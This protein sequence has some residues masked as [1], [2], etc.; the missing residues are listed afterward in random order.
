MALLI[1]PLFTAGIAVGGIQNANAGGPI[2]IVVDDD[3]NYDVFPPVT[4]ADCEGDNFTNAQI[5][6][7]DAVDLA[8]PG[9]TVVVCPGT[10]NESVDVD[11]EEDVTIEG[12]TK[13]KVDGTGSSPAFVITE[14]GTH[15]TGFE[16][17][18]SDNHCIVVDANDVRL[19]GNIASGCSG[20]GIQVI[21]DSDRIT[22]SGNQI[23][24]NGD[25]GIRISGGN[26][27]STIRGNTIT[28]NNN[29]GLKCSSCDDI[30]IQGNTV[31]DN[32]GDG[33]KCSSCTSSVIQGNISNLNDDDGIDINGSSDDNLVKGN[34]ANGNDGNGIAVRGEDNTF[35]GN[36]ANGNTLNGFLLDGGSLG[37]LVKGNTANDNVGYGFFDDEDNAFGKNQCRNNTA[38]GSNPAGLCKPQGFI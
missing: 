9:D 20:K 37:N 38:G 25:H 19:H 2:T 30:V 10:Y 32:G 8:M 21:G 17:F 7:Q 33:I 29:H 18:S 27:D 36:K 13:P 28:G 35:R 24:D 12:I 23:N 14:D 6:I 31:I 1:A 5:T 26:D 15:V 11:T 34:T 22:I 3:G 16:A 4:A